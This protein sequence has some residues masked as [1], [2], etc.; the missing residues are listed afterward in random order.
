MKQ[1]WLGWCAMGSLMLVAACG[2]RSTT[3]PAGSKGAAS[4]ASDSQLEQRARLRARLAEV[5]AG[6]RRIASGGTVD[7]AQIDRVRA[8]LAPRLSR[9]IDDLERK[10]TPLGTQRVDLGGRLGSAHVAHRRADGSYQTSC[11]T[12]HA[13][14]EAL[15]RTLGGDK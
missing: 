12:S 1:L 5:V 6:D 9:R 7:R 10:R 3:A 15:V 11:V 2:D 4:A 8:A 13:E 14:L